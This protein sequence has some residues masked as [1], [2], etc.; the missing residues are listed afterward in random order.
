[1]PGLSPVLSAAAVALPA[2]AAYQAASATSPC[3]SERIGIWFD[4]ESAQLRP[5]GEQVALAFALARLRF[6]VDGTG[7]SDA[8][9]RR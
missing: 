1:M 6:R 5:G 9:V 8:V 3:R 2:A 7:A 4:G